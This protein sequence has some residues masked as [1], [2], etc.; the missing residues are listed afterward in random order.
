[1]LDKE[2]IA[3]DKIPGI[4]GSVILT[5]AVNNIKVRLSPNKTI[6]YMEVP[7]T[8]VGGY[9]E[10]NK[11]KPGQAE[12]GCA[13]G[14]KLKTW[15]QVFLHESCHMDQYLEDSQVWLDTITSDDEY[16]STPFFEWLA[17]YD[18]EP[19]YDVNHLAK[20]LC[21][22]E[23][24]CEKRTV[25]KIIDYGLSDIIDV[26]KYIQQAN[27]YAY[28][29]LYLPEIRRWWE[30]GKEPYRNKLIWSKAPMTLGDQTVIPPELLTAFKE[31]L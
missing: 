27:A 23:F 14:T 30:T 22:V 4:V 9:F 6:D 8:P 26:T 18:I 7:N 12:F 15:I 21:A 16:T 2:K 1:M 29:Y 5:C 31:H 19:K 24:D 20:T 28:S 10:G 25:Q 3:Y 11:N 13:V 17:G